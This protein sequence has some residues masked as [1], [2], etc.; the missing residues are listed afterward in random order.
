MRSLVLISLV[1]MEQR[2]K[3]TFI[4]YSHYKNSI[5]LGHSK[6]RQMGQLAP[7]FHTLCG[8]RAAARHGADLSVPY[9][10]ISH[11]V[12]PQLEMR[13]RRFTAEDLY[14]ISRDFSEG[15]YA[16]RSHN[17]GCFYMK[18]VIYCQFNRSIID[19]NGSSMYSLQC[20]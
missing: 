16:Y 5:Q 6:S 13:K 1:D 7:S 19:D 11:V 9:S 8:F 4:Y 10:L 17:D 2:A 15:T 20:K 14:N 3:E 12:F 18:D